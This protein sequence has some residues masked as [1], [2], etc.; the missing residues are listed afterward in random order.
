MALARFWIRCF[1]HSL[2]IVFVMICLNVSVKRPF[3]TDRTYLLFGTVSEF[4]LRF[5]SGKHYSDPNPIP[6]SLQYIFYCYCCLLFCL[7]FFVVVFLLLFF[8]LFCFFC[9]CCFVF[10]FFVFFVFCFFCFLLLIFFCI[11]LF[12]FILFFFS[13]G[14]SKAIPPLIQ[15]F[16][17]TSVIAAVPGLLCFALR[18]HA[19]SN[20]LKISPPKTA[21]F[22]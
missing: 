13:A 17:R 18:K 15:F 3:C 12:Y 2:G 21:I 16:D 9:C 8:V 11:V 6:H 20:I 4:R 22:R 1:V 19:Y 10:F 7:L 14:W 5:R